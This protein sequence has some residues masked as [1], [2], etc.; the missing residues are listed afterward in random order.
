MQT[1]LIVAVLLGTYVDKVNGLVI[2]VMHERADGHYRLLGT[3]PRTRLPMR[4]ESVSND[5]A[6][7]HR[8]EPSVR[9]LQAAGADARSPKMIRF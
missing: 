1:R 3:T 8:G 9:T 2:E 4:S 7:G 5:I 6:E